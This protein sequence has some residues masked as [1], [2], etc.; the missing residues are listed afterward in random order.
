VFSVGDVYVYAH[1]D[2]TALYNSEYEGVTAVDHVS[3]SLM[4]LQPDVIVLYDRAATRAD[5]P[6]S[7]FWLNFPADAV[8]DGAV[9]RMTTDSGQTL[10]VETLLPAAPVIKVEP[11]VDEVSSA[12]ASN[13]SM[14]HRLMVESAA[15][16]SRFLHVLH[17]ADTGVTPPASTM[18]ASSDGTAYAG[19]QIGDS[20]VLFPVDAAAAFESLAVTTTAHTVYVTGLTP[21]A[22]FDAAWEGDTL[23]VTLGT[24]GAVADSGGV[25][26]ARR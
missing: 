19:A 16:E 6:V 11:L 17:G 18:I 20:A 21:G 2:S 4:W 3:R 10:T 22:G 5:N 7:R 9:T 26:V 25:L 15:A 24:T 12:P 8:V 1:G 13:E 23:R 14:T